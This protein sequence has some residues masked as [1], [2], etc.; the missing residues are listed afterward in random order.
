MFRTLVFFGLI[1]SAFAGESLDALLHASRGFSTAIQQQI[2][3]IARGPSLIEFVAKTIVYA[4]A[5]TAY[6]NALREAAPELM[7]IA[8]G[9]EV[10]PP[11]LD[12]M[13]EVFV[14]SGEQIS[15][16]LRI[17]FASFLTAESPGLMGIKD[18]GEFKFSAIER[19]RGILHA[20]VKVSLKTSP[21]PYWAAAKVFEA[22][23]VST[24]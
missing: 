3:A 14:V 8:T 10:R 23:N 24:P 4:D 20:T 7:N 16:W 6:F 21:M 17:A 11:E 15:D 18:L 22:W 12:T 5:K 19:F 1:T 13:A 9:R 2:L